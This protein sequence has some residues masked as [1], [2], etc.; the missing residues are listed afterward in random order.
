MGIRKLA[1]AAV[2]GV[3]MVSGAVFA[4]EPIEAEDVGEEAIEEEVPPPAPA[5]P[6]VAVA[7]APAVEAPAPVAVPAAPAKAETKVEFY[8]AVQ[9]RLRENLTSRDYEVQKYKVNKDSADVPID[10]VKTGSVNSVTG[11]TSD[12]FNM[13][14]WRAGLKAKVNDELSLQIQIGNDWGAGEGFS[15]SNNNMPSARVGFQNLYVHIASFKW[16]P[17]CLFV[18]GGVI[19]IPSSGT[20]DLL[21]RSLNK[22]HYGEAGFQGWS[23]EANA[24]LLGLK[25]GVPI[26]TDGIKLGV[27]LFQSLID[28]RSQAMAASEEIPPNPTSPLFVLTVPVEA[29]S[30]KLTPELTMVLNRNYNRKLEKGDN[31]VIF[32]LGGSY[33][34]NKGLSFSLLSGYGSVSNENSKAGSYAFDNGTNRTNADRV[35]TVDQAAADKIKAYN[36]T[37]ILLGVGTK[38]KAGP[39]DVQIEFKYNSAVDTENEDY[40]KMDYIYADLRYG[41]KVNDKFTITPRYRAYYKGYPAEFKYSY[42]AQNRIMSNLVNRL[43]LILEGSF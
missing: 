4:Q 37:G 23:T 1:V 42:S 34:V 14:S 29:G 10:T 21:E 36:S 27:E 25:V 43:E 7:P 9:Y 38:I 32:G 33:A 19:N 11:S 13:F 18:E 20:L 3:F 40:T 16:N 6:V 22:G 15:W 2:V 24:S 39:G 31:E 8:G 17:G 26:L 28:Q 5:A 12:Y 41:L 35:D 30:L